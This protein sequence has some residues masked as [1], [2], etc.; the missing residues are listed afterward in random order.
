MAR[1][2]IRVTLIHCETDV[3]VFK[4][5]VSS[6]IQFSSRS[7]MRFVNARGKEWVTALGTEEVLFV[8]GPFTERGIIESYETLVD[9]SGLTVIAARSEVLQTPLDQSAILPWY[10]LES[11]PHDN[12]N[13]NRASR[14]AQMS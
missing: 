2:A 8:V 9:D 14:R 10:L 7:V 6:D 1:L 4:R 12:P 13:G 3:I 5:P 11:S